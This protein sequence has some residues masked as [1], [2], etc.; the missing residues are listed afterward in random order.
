MSQKIIRKTGRLRLAGRLLLIKRALKR[1]CTHKPRNE[2]KVV[3]ALSKTYLADMAAIAFTQ[4]DSEP[5]QEAAGIP[6]S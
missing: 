5:F 2:E 4:L 1:S 3:D 6:V